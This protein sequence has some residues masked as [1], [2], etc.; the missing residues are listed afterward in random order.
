VLTETRTKTIVWQYDR[1]PDMNYLP[2][3]EAESQAMLA[4][5][6]V[7]SFDQLVES[8]PA[9]LRQSRPQLPPPLSEMELVREIEGLARRNRPLGDVLSFIGAG[10]YE[11]FIP[12]AID[13]LVSRGE[14]ATAGA[15]YQAE[16]SQGTLQAMYEYQSAI[17]ALT[18][19]EVSNASLYDGAS[20]LAEAAIL[21]LRANPARDRIVLAA[22]LHPDCQ[23][24]VRTYLA[25]HR[26]ELVTAPA[27]NGT[28]DLEALRRL[29]DRRTC[30]VLAQSP[31]FFGCI[32][33]MR[34]IADTAHHQGAF[35]VASVN[36]ISLGLLTPPGEYHAEFAVGEGQPLGI[37]LSY[38]G[39]WL[40]FLACPKKLVHRISGRLVGRGVDEA[41]DAGFCLVLQARE[42]HVQRE[43]ALSNVCSNQSL[44]A[45]RACIY[46][47]LLGGRGL[48]ELARLNFQL[49]HRAAKAIGRLPGFSLPFEAP[50]FN[51][52]VVRCPRPAEE[53]ARSL[54]EE[55]ILPGRP[56]RGDE[57]GNPNDLL[58]CV[59]ETKQMNDIDRL[60]AALERFKR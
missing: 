18:D 33:P 50:F 14:F 55:G 13:P 43:K 32:E 25:G 44:M 38:G 6:G 17:C 47:A 37:P 9:A 31:N 8:I 49:A 7:K 46:L 1:P 16:A 51:E 58:V 39:P 56:F 20:A 26:V 19:M 22:S 41:D 5:I 28:V 35:L 45:L 27:A 34:R 59:T 2:Q 52:F 57:N 36:P 42:P 54:E 24:T 29:V 11:H 15:P 40:G 23:A 12:S 21:S 3:T 4:A 53:I 10:A 60:V 48:A 30:A